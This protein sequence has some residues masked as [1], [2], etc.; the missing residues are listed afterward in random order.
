MKMMQSDMGAEL[1]DELDSADLNQIRN[2][3]WKAA[4]LLEVK[5]SDLHSKDAQTFSALAKA[6]DDL[7]GA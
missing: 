1:R 6:I 7:Y 3:C 4:F 5:H 2:F